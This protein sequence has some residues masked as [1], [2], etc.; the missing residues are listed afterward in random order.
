MLIDTKNFI[1]ISEANQNFSK[2]AKLVDENGSVVV[3]KNNQPKYVIIEFSDLENNE[4]ADIEEVKSL[5]SSIINR[6]L[7]AFKELAK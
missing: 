2:I 3:L 4:V 7:N 6:N 5:S 1:S